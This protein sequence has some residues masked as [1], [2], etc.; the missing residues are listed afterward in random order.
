MT[1]AKNTEQEC[2]NCGGTPMGT[3][4]YH[5]CHNSTHYYSAEQERADDPF[6]GDDDVRERYMEWCPRHGAYAGDCGGCEAEHYARMDAEEEGREFDPEA[7]AAFRADP[8]RIALVERILDIPV[9]K[10]DFLH[11]V[12][13]A[14]ADEDIPF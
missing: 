8:A 7:F 2:P 3:G 13:P 11:G 10:E 1:T 14:P 12:G 5:I 4:C 9:T 6:Y